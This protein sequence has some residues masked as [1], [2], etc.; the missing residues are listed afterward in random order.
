[1]LKEVR[2]GFGLEGLGDLQGRIVSDMGSSPTPGASMEFPRRE[3][4]RAAAKNLVLPAFMIR[5]GK[6]WRLVHYEADILSRVPWGEIDV[7][8]LSKLAL[9]DADRK[10]VEIRTGLDEGTLEGDPVVAAQALETESS[11]DLDYAFAASHLL[12]VMPNP[13]RGAELARRVF[14]ALTKKYDRK[15][16]ISNFVFVLEEVRR[17]VEQERDRLAQQVFA[18]LL[19][20]GTMRFMVVMDELG[21]NRPPRKVS[22]PAGTKKGN[23][24]DGNQFEMDLFGFVAEDDLNGLENMVASYLDKQERLFFWYRNRARHDYFVQGWKRGRIFADFI[25]TLRSDE[26]DADDK[27]H[28]V[29][30]TETKGLHLKRAA[31]TDYKRSVF[32]LCSK[33]AKRKDWADFVPAMRGKVMRFEVVD[34]EEWENRLNGLLE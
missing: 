13:W 24:E 28:K 20:Q 23:R 8:P 3:K 1:M 32:E 19:E 9:S 26:S 22:V 16:V 25:F 12:D 4:F 18:D 15:R 33:H 21:F 11:G 27:F 17:C 5:D 29:F 14:D 2:K 10:D 6:E 34:E 30:V 7:S 31:D